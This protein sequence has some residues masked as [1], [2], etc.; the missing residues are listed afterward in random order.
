MLPLTA[1]H[2]GRWLYPVRKILVAEE[3]WDKGTKSDPSLMEGSRSSST[4]AVGRTA[5]LPFSDL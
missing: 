4:F 1:G 5:D 2:S 3:P